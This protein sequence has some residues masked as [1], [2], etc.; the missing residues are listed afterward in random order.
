VSEIA[1]DKYARKRAYHWTECFGPLHRRN[2]Y[3]IG[4]YEMVLAALRSA[5]IGA[6]HRVLDVGCGDGALTGLIAMR[7]GARVHGVDSTADSVELARREFAKRG[8]SGHFEAIAGYGYPF[9]DAS[10]PAVVCSDVIEHVQ[11]PADMLREMWR[12]L[13][14]EGILVVTT[15]VRYTEAPLDRMHVQEWFPEGFRRFCGETLGVP[16]DLKLSHPVA[17]AELSASAS[18]VMGRVARLSLNLLTAL[19]RNPF[20]RTR[21]FRALSAQTAIARKPVQP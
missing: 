11:N 5:G 19:G 9:P 18:P 4:R 10:F 12:V 16:V 6:G 1:F 13:A 2:A 3:T 20:L 7:T 14:P 21:G 15:P 17:L 8:L